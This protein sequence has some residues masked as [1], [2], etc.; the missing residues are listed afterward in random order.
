MTRITRNEM[1]LQLF[2][3]NLET[4]FGFGLS[5]MFLSSFLDAVCVIYLEEIAG[6]L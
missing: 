1:K 2:F 5:K 3:F 6:I 4:R